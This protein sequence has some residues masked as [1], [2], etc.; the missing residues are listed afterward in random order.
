MSEDWF[1]PEEQRKIAV[2]FMEGAE[3]AALA[4]DYD[5]DRESIEVV[6]REQLQIRPGGGSQES[7]PRH[8]D[9]EET[10]G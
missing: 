8:T 3:V 9:H 2:G 7:P 4:F 5:A 6:L 10:K 1:T